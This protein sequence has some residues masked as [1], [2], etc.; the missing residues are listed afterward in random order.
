M[1]DRMIQI[2]NRMAKR[3]I[4]GESEKSV[5]KYLAWCGWQKSDADAMIRKAKQIIEVDADAGKT[6]RI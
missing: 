3:M 6:E 5:N 1:D 4:S 2:S